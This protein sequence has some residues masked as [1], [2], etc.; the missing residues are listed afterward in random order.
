VRGYIHP[1]PESEAVADYYDAYWSDGGT[2]VGSRLTTLTRQAIH[3]RTGPD[4]RCLDFGCGD[5]SV[6]TAVAGE[7]D[8][9]VGVDISD[10]AAERAR[11]LGLE[12]HVIDPG[13][14]IPA[15]SESVDLALCLEVFEHLEVPQE[16]ASE[17]ARCLRPHG[18]LIATTP[19]VGYW[20]QR[21]DLAVLGRFNPRGDVL[22]AAE[23]W[24]DPHLRFFTTRSL[25]DMLRNSGFREVE[26]RGHDGAFLAD[27]PLVRR[28]ARQRSSAFYRRLEAIAPTLLGG[29]L[30]AIA[31]K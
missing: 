17:L 11:S 19:N 7:V 21:F 16:V 9:Y 18:V 4:T 10:V 2:Y 20:R 27:L 29:R 26:V 1:V 14:S 6:G 28:L 8:S 31:T 25:G 15:E 3:A 30:L 13:S 5:G 24:R 22:S 23:P 12:V